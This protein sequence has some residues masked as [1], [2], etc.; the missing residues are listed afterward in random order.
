MSLSNLAPR[1]TDSAGA[2]QSS[3]PN[4]IIAEVIRALREIRFGSVE[5][6]IHE[7]RVVQIECREKRRF[8]LSRKI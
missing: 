2:H 1:T 3:L 4:D 6:T 5:I 8:E 7:S